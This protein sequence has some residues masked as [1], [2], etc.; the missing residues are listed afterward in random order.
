MIAYSEFGGPIVVAA[1]LLGAMLVD[2][3]LR[4]L[5]IGWPGGLSFI[6]FI[7]IYLTLSALNA[8]DAH[9]EKES[10]IRREYIKPCSV[11]IP[12]LTG[13]SLVVLSHINSNLFI[14]VLCLDGPP[15]GVK[16]AGI[17]ELL[18]AIGVVLVSLPVVE[19]SP[20][21]WH[22]SLRVNIAYPLFFIS[23]LAYFSMSIISSILA[24][25]KESLTDMSN[26]LALVVFMSGI[27]VV[28]SE[29]LH[30]RKK[31]VN[32]RDEKI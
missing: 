16:G 1:S 3:S 17:S 29:A 9:D 21:G 25:P 30:E 4:R 6:S 26:Q 24:S 31:R 19:L 27:V 18:L 12:I 20:V 8:D 11:S 15:I 28:A 2:L 13:L 23:S 22:E 7:L 5:D 14:R 10:F 32:P